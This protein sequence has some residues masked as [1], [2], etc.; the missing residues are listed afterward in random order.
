M[1]VDLTQ[2]PFHD[3][4]FRDGDGRLWGVFR[5]ESGYLGRNKR[6]SECSLI[7]MSEDGEQ[8]ELPRHESDPRTDQLSNDRICELLKLAG[9]LDG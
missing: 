7:F 1:A 6:R 3:Y 9:G 2:P 5:T 8:R 4:Q